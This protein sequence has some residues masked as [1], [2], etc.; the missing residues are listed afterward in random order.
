MQK[1]LLILSLFFSQIL[2]AQRG[3]LYVKK[4]GY[5]KVKTFE[6]GS[7]IKFET[8]D[9]QIIYGEL[10]LVLKDSIYVND[11]R[12]AASDIKKIILKQ[13]G[14]G[15]FDYETFLWTTGGVILATAGMT[16]AKWA[17]VETAFAFSAGIGY[18]NYLIRY[19]PKFKRKAYSIGKKFSLQTLDLHF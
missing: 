11:H 3:F 15:G 2:F 19:F 8:K 4:H 18:G 17:S 5:K 13:K 14:S 16:L 7:A 9:G 10:A 6:E 1:L 12:F